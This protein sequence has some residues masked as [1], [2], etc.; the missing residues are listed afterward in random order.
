ML[1]AGLPVRLTL[2]LSPL[3]LGGRT[4]FDRRRFRH[5]LAHDGSRDTGE[6]AAVPIELL[7]QRLRAV[8]EQMP[9]IRDLDRPGGAA[10]HAIGVG[11]GAVTSHDLD[12]GMSLQPVGH[13]G[14]LAVGRYTERLAGA[15]IEPSVGSVGD[16][17]DSAYAK[18]I[19]GLFKA[20]VIHR[21]GPWRSFEAVESATLER[22]DWYNH[23]RLLAPIGNVPP[24]EA[25]ARYHTHVS[26]QALAA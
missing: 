16:S 10:T 1:E 18:T 17:Y 20:E 7:H 19:N 23:R 22:V 11:T 6:L 25:E 5:G 3:C 24:A 9:S 4:G 14:G 12:A 13:G 8:A 15:G 2:L 26:D 21:R